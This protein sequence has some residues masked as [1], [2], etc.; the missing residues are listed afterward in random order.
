M[1]NARNETQAT[2]NADSRVT[3]TTSDVRADERLA[4]FRSNESSMALT[5]Q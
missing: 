3:R 2:R 1:R 4:L 5:M